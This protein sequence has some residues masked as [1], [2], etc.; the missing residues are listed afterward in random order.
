[1]KK[2]LALLA[3]VLAQTSFG[4]LQ[5]SD[6]QQIQPRNALTN[7]GFENGKAGYSAYADAAATTPVD[8]TGGSPT[9]TIT[10]STTSPLAGSVSGIITKDA[11]NR[12]GEGVSIPFTIQTADQAKVMQISFDYLIGSG[13]FAAGSSSTDSDIEVYIYDV[14]NAQLIQPSTYKLYG[15]PTSYTAKYIANFQTAYN[16]TSYRLIFHVA[17]TSA[18]AYTL[19]YDNI[20]VA[21]TQYVYG[22]PITDWTSFTPTGSWSTNTTY[23]GKYR[24]VGDSM[25]VQSYVLLS[26]A[27]TSATLTVNLPNGYS[28]DTTKL[29]NAGTEVPVLGK[30]QAFDAGV[31][32]YQVRVHYN[33]TTSVLVRVMNAG[34]T[35]ISNNNVTQAVPFTFGSSDYVEMS[36]SV[37]IQGWSSSVQTSD[38]SDSRTLIEAYN[39]NAGTVLTANTTN[40]DFS[41][42]VTDTHGAWSGT[43]FTA[44]AP[45]NYS[46]KGSISCTTGASRAF[47]AYVNGTQNKL[48]AVTTTGNVTH[49]VA[50]TFLNANDTFSLRSNASCTLNA[51]ATDHWINITRSP[52]S[53]VISATET[54]AAVIQGT[55]AVWSANG[56]VIFPTATKD[57]HGAYN[58]STGRYTVP[59]SGLY[60][61]STFVGTNNGPSKTYLFKN[62]S[63]FAVIGQ[64][65][66]SLG[67]GGSGIVPCVAG[68]ILDIRNE[69]SGGTPA[70]SILSILRVG[71]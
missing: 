26:G 15:N 40:I 8:G 13:T 41:T 47:Y 48:V 34:G 57:T 56:I 12:Q 32:N 58:A 20:S 66:S 36:Y 7:G 43:V 50:D 46:I 11:A 5:E 21:A 1:M 52:S 39:N 33:N 55:P 64:S 29:L 31:Q 2:M 24:R 54:V 71:N 18:S 9:V 62:G 28:V 23:T 27:P 53:S 67:G 14:T 30:G 19:K 65:P 49:F 37:P 3:I 63:Q 45:G 6:R 17:T 51:V 69:T 68:D 4:A 25:E 70:A 44:N 22:T 38:Q 35:Y 10:T 59:Y 42:K 60:N 61:V 16:S